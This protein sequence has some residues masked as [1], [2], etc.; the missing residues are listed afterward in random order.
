VHRSGYPNSC[1]L[2]DYANGFDVIGIFAQL[3]VC[4]A[5]QL[6]RELDEWRL[7]TVL[8]D[9]LP[10]DSDILVEQR[11]LESPWI[12]PAEHSFGEKIFRCVRSAAGAV[13]HLERDGRLDAALREGG[14]RFACRP[15]VNCQQRLVH[16]FDGVAR[17]N[18]TASDDVPSERLE[19][20]PGTHD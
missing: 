9:D 16:R 4:L 15:D 1:T 17:A 3:A 14:E 11:E 7:E 2:L 5:E 10:R 19:Y 13:Y 12:F 18:V 20:R 8:F 6:R